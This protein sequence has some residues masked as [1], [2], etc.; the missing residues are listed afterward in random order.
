MLWNCHGAHGQEFRR[1]L[2]FLLD[3]NN[4]TIS[5]LTETRIEDHFAILNDFNF[6]DLIQVAAQGYTG[7]IV[8]LWRADEL[9][10]DP[11]VV[12]AQEIHATV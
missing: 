4:P 10:V 9:I 2:R 7:G 5:C 1:N 12:T 6:T 8:M 11:L 3:W